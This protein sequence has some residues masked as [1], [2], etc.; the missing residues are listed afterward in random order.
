MKPKAFIDAV[1][2]YIDFFGLH[3]V[4]IA[5]SGAPDSTD[6][7]LAF[8]ESHELTYDDSPRCYEIFYTKNWIERTTEREVWRVAF[9][10][11]MEVMLFSLLKFATNRTLIV[12]DREVDDAAHAIIKRFENKIFPLIGG[13]K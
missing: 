6:S 7:T 1:N 2:F 11:V 5:V 13:K 8:T 12:T 10:E 4:E 3:D 9:H